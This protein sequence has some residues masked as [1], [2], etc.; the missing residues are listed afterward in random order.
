MANE[1]HRAQRIQSEFQKLLD[2]LK[3]Q[4]EQLDALFAQAGIRRDEL[5]D[6]TPEAAARVLASFEDAA[7]TRRLEL[8]SERRPPSVK[9]TGLVLRA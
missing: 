6:V 2:E 7:E 3:E 4:D 9:L 8:L 5:P 1:Q